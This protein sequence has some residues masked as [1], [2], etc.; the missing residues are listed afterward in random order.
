METVEISEDI[1]IDMLWERINEF[2]PAKAYDKNFWADCI[3]YLSEIGWMGEPRY[4]NPMY[5]V[6]NVAVGDICAIED[7]ANNYDAIDN[8]YDGDVTAWI[9]DNGYLVF[10]D[11]VVINLGL[12]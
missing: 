8:K 11:Y 1:F 12:D 7:C 2:Q 5:I 3:D 6:D 10:G 9:E 4:N